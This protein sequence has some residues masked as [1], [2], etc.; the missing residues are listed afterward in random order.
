[1]KDFW[2][3]LI[4]LETQ[5]MYIEEIPTKKESKYFMN[6]TQIRFELL[7]N[8]KQDTAWLCVNPTSAEAGRVQNSLKKKQSPGLRR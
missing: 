2:R 8:R 5:Q 3:W 7:T 4:S 1:M 6:M